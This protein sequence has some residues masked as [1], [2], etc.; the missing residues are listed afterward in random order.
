MNCNVLMQRWFFGIG[1]EGWK[2][3]DVIILDDTKK[4]VSLYGLVEGVHNHK[5]GEAAV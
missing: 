5:I 2:G 3:W 1:E 4:V